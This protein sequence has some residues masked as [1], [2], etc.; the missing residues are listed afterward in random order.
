MIEVF[1]TRVNCFPAN[2]SLF[3]FQ[4]K[5]LHN[6]L[7]VIFQKDCHFSV[8]I[9][10]NLQAYLPIQYTNGDN[11]NALLTLNKSDVA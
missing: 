3:Y 11:F 1:K 4:F 10:Q 5:Q 9:K 7:K 6:P 8:F 2:N